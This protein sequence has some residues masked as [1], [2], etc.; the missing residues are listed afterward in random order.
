MHVKHVH[1]GRKQ[2]LEINMHLLRIKRAESTCHG[3]GGGG[4]GG[5]GNSIRRH[6]VELHCMKR[7]RTIYITICLCLHS[8]YHF[9]CARLYAT[10]YIVNITFMYPWNANEEGMFSLISIKDEIIIS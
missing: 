2:M 3:G 5:D 6:I 9:E 4:G 10:V 8:A 7:P 1:D